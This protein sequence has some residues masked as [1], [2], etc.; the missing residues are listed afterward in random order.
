MIAASACRTMPPSALCAVSLSGVGR[1]YSPGPIVRGGERAA[2]MYTLIAKAKVN[3]PIRE[4]GSPTRAAPHRRPCSP[5]IEAPPNLSRSRI[6]SRL[7][8]THYGPGR[9]LALVL[10]NSALIETL[11]TDKPF[12]MKV[13]AY[14]IWTAGTILGSAAGKTRSFERTP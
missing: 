3:G 7:T 6:R 4:L 8:I 9:M 13:V 11:Y 1:G 5:V 10:V 14:L 2:A 12:P